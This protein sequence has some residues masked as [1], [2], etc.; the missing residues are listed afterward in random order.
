MRRLVA[1]LLLSS[2]LFTVLSGCGAVRIQGFAGT[3]FATVSGFVSGVQITTVAGASG[4]LIV[5][6]VVTFQQTLGFITSNFCG[7]FGS[8]FPINSFA[9]VSFR[10]GQPCS[11]VVVIIIN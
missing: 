6:T 2:L 4:T 5:V 9:Q 10:P 11:S 3:G 7:N 1:C 8:R